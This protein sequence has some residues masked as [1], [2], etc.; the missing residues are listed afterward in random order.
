MRRVVEQRV[1]LREHIAAEH[2]DRRQQQRQLWGDGVI[3]GIPSHIDALVA[4]IGPVAIAG[5]F[6]RWQILG[7]YVWPNAF[8]GDTHQEDVDYLKTWLST[9]AEWMHEQYT[10]EFGACP[11]A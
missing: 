9:R 8:V 3:A 4:E 11:A 5:N 6:D 7:E 10:S 1:A 2:H